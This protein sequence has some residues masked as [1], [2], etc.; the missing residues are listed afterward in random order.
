[1]FLRP[2]GDLNL[3]LEYLLA[4]AVERHGVQLHAYCFMS[5]H[6]HLVLTDPRGVL[7]AF[8]QYLASLIARSCNALLGRRE[9]FWSPGPFS[10]VELVEAGDVFDK[11]AYTLANPVAAELVPR[12]GDWPGL[13]SSPEAIGGPTTTV[14]RPGGFFRREGPMP[15]KAELALVA[16]P[17]VEDAG[18]FRRALREELTRREGET[19]ERLAS[20]GRTFLG[21]Q[22]VLEQRSSAQPTQEEP[23]PRL[24]PRV[25]CKDP[26]KRRDALRRLR[27]F[28]GAYREAWAEFASGLRETMFPHGTYWMRVAYGVPCAGSG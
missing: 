9:S 24:H 11:V 18:A 15:A 7:P 13:W 16:P 10:A 4:V 2:S 5:N 8:E 19:M 22:G 14:E 20:E 23:V 1:M 27:A 12:G 28:L 17:G 3:L 26:A 6:F 21:V 25:A